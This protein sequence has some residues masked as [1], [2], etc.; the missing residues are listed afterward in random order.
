MLLLITNTYT[1][2]Q[3]TQLLHFSQVLKC[4]FQEFKEASFIF[5]PFI[6][7][8]PPAPGA[9]RKWVTLNCSDTSRVKQTD[10]K[11]IPNGTPTELHVDA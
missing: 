7:I 2:Q 10:P 5:I 8:S 6:L 4:T 11:N 1:A 9:A 3:Q